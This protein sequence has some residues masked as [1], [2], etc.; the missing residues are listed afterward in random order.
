MWFV[1]DGRT[2]IGP[3]SEQ[4]IC[5]RV[6]GGEW[7]L[8]VYVRPESSSVYRP[9]LWMLPKWTSNTKETEH[10][11]VRGNEP[12]HEATQIAS[13]V[14]LENAS[15][16][17]S[18]ASVPAPHPSPAATVKQSP[19]AAPAQEPVLA[20]IPQPPPDWGKTKAQQKSEQNSSEPQF[21]PRTKKIVDE[22]S[23]QD[24][25]FADLEPLS[26]FSQTPATPVSLQPRMR[27]NTPEGSRSENSV[28][29]AATA[30]IVEGERQT[31]EFE[32]RQG[33]A[34]ADAV[35]FAP[36]F[37]VAQPSKDPHL[38]VQSPAHASEGMVSLVDHES[39]TQ[40]KFRR[41]N[42]TAPRKRGRASNRR[43]MDK[44][45]VNSLRKMLTGNKNEASFW[46][47]P[48][49][50]GVIAFA[51]IMVI[52]AGVTIYDKRQILKE[53]REQN[54][55]QVAEN[56]QAQSGASSVQNDSQESPTG[57]RKKKKKKLNARPLNT[58]E[59]K[60]AANRSK[61]FE[62]TAE[63]SR[64]LA[65]SGA[66]GFIV[67][68]PV[69]LQKPAGGGCSPCR[70]SGKFTDGSAISLVSFVDQPWQEVVGST[71]V[72]AR[73]FLTE[74]EKGKL[75]LTVNKLSEKPF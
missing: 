17:N 13:R 22:P 5:R 51:V 4:E 30:A 43:L 12:M 40:I 9:L 6:A 33:S 7:P 16:R 2:R 52:F 74:N 39:A 21:T 15:L 34:K 70:I 18:T 45:P 27:D 53:M 31:R 67:V 59:G 55:L 73:G 54:N 58:G 72:Y 23:E 46:N 41:L 62:N 8:V 14:Y 32:K 71:I 68:G 19:P 60:S 75:I 56:N 28:I 57:T 25:S 47:N 63:L 69:R 66:R 38:S 29:R 61:I 35:E 1:W 37:Q 49:T 3:M 50:I 36:A 24:I 11:I 26:P 64:Y 65:S 48:L 20:A 10:T 42:P 44:G